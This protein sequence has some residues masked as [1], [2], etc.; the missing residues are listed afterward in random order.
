MEERT[1]GVFRNLSETREF[2]CYVP[3]VTFTEANK[4]QAFVVKVPLPFTARFVSLLQIT[5]PIAGF[6]KAAV[7]DMIP[8]VVA[9]GFLVDPSYEL[10]RTWYITCAFPN[11]PIPWA[12]ISE[13]SRRGDVLTMSL[14]ATVHSGVPLLHAAVL[15]EESSEE[16]EAELEKELAEAEYTVIPAKMYHASNELINFY[17]AQVSQEP[18]NPGP[19]L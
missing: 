8:S 4:N 2:R 12:E 15:L 6:L 19:D 16:A 18:K 1:A 10:M 7:G 14:G 11:F 13:S 9:Y 17:R 3:D 5:S